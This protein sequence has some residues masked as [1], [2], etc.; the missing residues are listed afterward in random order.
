M[1]IIEETVVCKIWFFLFEFRILKK[2]EK[3]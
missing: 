2:H 3:K 1:N